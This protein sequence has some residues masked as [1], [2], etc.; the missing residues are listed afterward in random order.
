MLART[1]FSDDATLAHTPRQENLSERVVYFVRAGVKQI[2]A[3]EINGRATGIFGQTPGQEKRRGPAGIIT[4]EC[5]K[6]MLKSFIRARRLISRCQFFQWRHKRLGHETTPV[7][8]PMAKRVRLC[9]GF[10]GSEF[11]L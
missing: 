6:F 1:G 9:K 8:P 10:H 11:K 2:F 5:I 3:L 7:L 4:Q